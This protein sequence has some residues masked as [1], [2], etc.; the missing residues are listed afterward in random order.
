MGYTNS[1][2]VSYTRLSPNHSGTRT[3]EIDTITIHMVVG[4]CSVQSLGAIFAPWSRQASSNYGV[5]SDGRI[6]MYCEEK[7][8]SWCS[9]S[10]ENDQRAITIETANDNYYPYAV[11]ATAYNA[12]IKLC[13]DIC[14]RNGKKK[15]IWCGSLAKTNAR[16]FAKNEMRMTLHKWFAD[17]SCPGKFLEDHMQDIANKVNALLDGG[18]W[19]KSGRK[20][21]YY[22]DGKKQT[23]WIKDQ[24]AWYYLND[25][26][27]MQTGWI[28]YKKKKYYL[29]S[30]G[31]MATGWQKIKNK[32]YYFET[33]KGYA[34][35][36]QQMVNNTK[37][38]FNEEGVLLSPKNP[39]N[40]FTPY[41]VKVN[42]DVLNIRAGAGT[43]YKITGVIT[44][45]GKYTIVAE[46]SGSGATKWGK[47]KSG[48]G[49]IALDWTSKV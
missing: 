13:A 1:P 7:N 6:G 4:Q 15:M 11:N 3:H 47:L 27:V 12:L 46:S 37:C 42:A 25:K 38:T 8:R 32:W 48:M 26:G 22:K 17:T 31:V 10:P 39:P 44:D 9:S 40:T 28:T 34:F 20:W 29:A 43:G 14:K 45:R 30:N 19:K 33:S 18:E 41:V 24:G 36:G 49:W 23:G 16:K 2:L 21:Y 5:G 35:T